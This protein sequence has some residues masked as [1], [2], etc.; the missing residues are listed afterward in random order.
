MAAALS[1]AEAMLEEE[2]RLRRERTHVRIGMQEQYAD[3]RA[4][5]ES[6]QSDV[7]T[8]LEMLK[9]PRG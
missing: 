9:G 3:L 7:A 5:I 8:I 6:I 1:R 2:Q 4:Q